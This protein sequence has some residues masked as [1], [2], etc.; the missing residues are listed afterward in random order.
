MTKRLVLM[1][2]LF[3]GGALADDFISQASIL[4]KD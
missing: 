2:P 4:Y 3:S 1:L